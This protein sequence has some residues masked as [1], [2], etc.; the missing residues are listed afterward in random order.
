MLL[1]TINQDFYCVNILKEEPFQQ[2]YV[3]TRFRFSNAPILLMSYTVEW[4]PLVHFVLLYLT[5]I[6]EKEDLILFRVIFLNNIL[7]IF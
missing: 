2:Q 3:R 4:L 7:I 1:F 6:Y 5:Y